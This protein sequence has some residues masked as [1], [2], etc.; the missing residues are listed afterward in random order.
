MQIDRDTN[1]FQTCK[2]G[3]TPT[4][5]SI[6][7]GRR[8]YYMHCECGKRMGDGMGGHP[9]TFIECWNHSVRHMEAGSYTTNRDMLSS[10]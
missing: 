9:D 6:G 1:K 7:Y 4:R 8:P 10:T 2:C 3:H 5:F